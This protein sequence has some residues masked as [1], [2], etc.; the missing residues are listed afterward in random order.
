MV[1]YQFSNTDKKKIEYAINE[2]LLKWQ[3]DE[4]F[5]TGSN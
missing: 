2:P 4:V 5:I 3:A 1:A